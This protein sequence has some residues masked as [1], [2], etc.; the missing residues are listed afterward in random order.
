[1]KS[2]FAS[3]AVLFSALAVMTEAHV[4]FRFPCPRRGPYWECPQPGPNDWNLVD[5]D[6]RSPMGTWGS[7]VSPICKWPSS[8]DGT[9]PT[10]QAGQTVQAQMDVGAY[11]LGGSCQWAL[12][13]DNGTNWVVFQDF[14]QN[15]LANAT[16]GSTF[17]LPFTIPANAPS[18]NA[19]VNWIWNNN[20][21]NR[22]LYSS[23]SDVVIQG[24]NGGS[25]SGVKPLFA[26]YGPNSPFI[27]EKALAN[28]DWGKAFFDARPSITVTVPKVS[29]RDLMRRLVNRITNSD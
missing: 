9:R 4:S 19:I 23:C 2:I 14:F 10:F 8:F 15:C 11:H 16:Q 22:E 3:A 6:I 26:N 27:Q 18:G 12:S 7:I 21:G 24:T 20:E 25:L 17:T 28:G 29:K 1:M 5:Y 13:Y